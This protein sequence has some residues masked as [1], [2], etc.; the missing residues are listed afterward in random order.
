MP[1]GLAARLTG[2]PERGWRRRHGVVLVA[3]WAAVGVVGAVAATVGPGAGRSA[4]EGVWLLPLAVVATV[5]VGWRVRTAAAAATVTGAAA[6]VAHLTE[7]AGPGVFMLAAVAL[8]WAYRSWLPFLV[9]V[10]VVAGFHV[11][12]DLVPGELVQWDEAAAEL[13]VVLAA[14]AA[15]VV[16]EV[17][18]ADVDRLRL[19][20]LLV[21][22][23]AE[24]GICGADLEGRGTFVNR[25]AARMYGFAEEELVGR[26]VHELTHHHR[27]DGSPYPPEQCPIRQAV[28]GGKRVHVSGEVFW[29]KDG[30]SFPVEYVAAPL[31]QGG[32]VVGGVVTFRDVSEQEAAR[33]AA[34]E[35]A[36]MAERQAAQTETVHLL[37]EAVRPPVP[38]VDHAEIGVYVLP[39]DPNAPTGGDLYDLHVLPDGD[40]HLAVVDVVGKGVAATKDAL[41]VVHALRL[42]V[43]D[44]CPPAQ[45]V[46]RAD[47]LVTAL[48][49]D[50][51]ATA[52]VARYT[53]STGVVRLAGAGHPP[54]LLL[55]ADGASRFV[56]APG[57]AIGWP[58]AGSEEVVEVKLER[59]DVLLLY[60]D[61][62]V[63]ATKDILAGFD[64]LQRA[65]A[66]TVS[67][68]APSLAR[69]P[70]ERA[71]AGS[72]R[73]DDTLAL[74]LRRRR[75]PD[76]PERPALRPFAHRFSPNT[77]AVPVARHL[78]QDWLRHQPVDPDAV[79]DLVLMA[80]ELCSNAVA[81]STGAPAALG[82]RSWIEGDAVV[83]EVSDDGPGLVLPDRPVEEP[84][85]GG[86]E[87][88]R[89][90]FIVRV[91][92][93]EVHAVHEDG[94][95]SVRVV[96]R[97]VAAGRRP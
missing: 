78:L 21:L 55:A 51:V 23:A 76:L 59:S 48:S 44:G 65:A 46:A 96:K 90:L 89:G 69:A 77:A 25:A 61:G 17:A 73:R 22:D 58:G 45:L 38:E 39:A 41:A 37:E 80:S 93:D 87:R 56:A 29:R 86:L 3:M 34:A 79:P 67:Y 28:T 36:R 54:A 75:P 92:A 60:T 43:L 8:L 97:S 15:R 13:V 16:N 20:H 47:R 18:W 6:T 63:E 95:S 40:L 62:L 74:V 33:R 42:L 11:V 66:E 1:P 30:T 26:S 57:I 88:G 82:L 35:L 84:P 64:G 10:A 12:L 9:A 7:V 81:A 85:D 68:P 94:R 52:L 19:Q 91:L 24:E 53:P 49:P 14:V 5:P 83:V 2:V 31:R 72:V 4:G 32:R 71:L 70:V 50:L 27:A